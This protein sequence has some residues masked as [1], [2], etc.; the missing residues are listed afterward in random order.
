MIAKGI[1]VWALREKAKT[2][3]PKNWTTDLASVFSLLPSQLCELPYDLA[4]SFLHRRY[5]YL[6]NPV[7]EISKWRNNRKKLRLERLNL[8]N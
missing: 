8:H 6:H 4:I 7:E 3:C 2:E 1:A 5:F